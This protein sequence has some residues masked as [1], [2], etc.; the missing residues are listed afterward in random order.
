MKIEVPNSEILDKYSILLIKSARV[1]D[2]E[3][4]VFIHQ[5]ISSFEKKIPSNFLELNQFLDLVNV[6]EKIWDLQDELRLKVK[7]RYFHYFTIFNICWQ[8]VLN[9]DER[10]RIKRKIDR[11]T[12]SK[13]FESKNFN[14]E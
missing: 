14:L 10:G 5:Q 6:N 13:Y 9:N 11:E 2:R 7:K 12:D 8:L 4:L 3:E 1:L